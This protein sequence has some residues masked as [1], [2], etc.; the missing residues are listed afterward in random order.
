MVSH[1]SSGASVLPTARNMRRVIGSR[2]RSS[3]CKESV[4][5][6]LIGCSACLSLARASLANSLQAVGR[7]EWLL[8]SLLQNMY[9]WITA[10]HADH[11]DTGC[12][13]RVVG[14][15]VVAKLFVECVWVQQNHERP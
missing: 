15:P 1:P 3:G 14:A 12:D 11:R 6:A 5:T 8:R 13:E 9:E 2:S 7:Y 4:M 10:T